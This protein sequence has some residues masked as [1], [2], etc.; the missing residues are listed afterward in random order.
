MQ[1]DSEDYYWGFESRN[2]LLK[3]LYHRFDDLGLEEHEELLRLVES[4]RMY[5][6][7]NFRLSE[8][9]K[10]SYLNFIRYFASILK[11]EDQLPSNR[12]LEELRQEIQDQQFLTHK[13]WLLDQI[14]EK[15]GS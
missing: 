8:F 1:E 2:M 9:H 4:F 10:K 11:F 5:I 12:L 13:A 7:Q 6:R 14:G 3:S 15:R